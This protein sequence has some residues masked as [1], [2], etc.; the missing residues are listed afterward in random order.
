MSALEEARKAYE[1]LEANV[2]REASPDAFIALKRELQEL[3]DEHLRLSDTEKKEMEHLHDT[4]E[5]RQ[6]H[7]FLDRC[8]IDSAAIPG[9]GNAKKAALR[10][11]GIETAADVEWNRVLAVRG[12]GEV[13]TGAV[14]DWRKSC[15]RRFVFDGRNAVTEA[16]RNAV[17]ARV[18]TR[19]R[20][21]EGLL[22]SG[23][24]D[25]RR[26]HDFAEKNERAASSQLLE[27]AERFAKAKA[28]AAVLWT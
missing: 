2:R 19:R 21:I 26:L 11:I 18:A 28:D 23:P 8:F 22:L 4:A 12:F 3:R 14:V 7:A 10:S 27:L 5:Q 20:A 1:E 16:D 17:R 13:L 6:K 9:V 15:E 25:L 24:N